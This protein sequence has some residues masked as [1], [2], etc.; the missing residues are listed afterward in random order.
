M[1]YTNEDVSEGTYDA[2]PMPVEKGRIR[3]FYQEYMTNGGTPEHS[4]FTIRCKDGTMKNV[5]A[6]FATIQYG[7]KPAIL[8]L[9][10]DGLNPREAK[11]DFDALDAPQT[12]AE[13]KVARVLTALLKELVREE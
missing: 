8:A 11:T 10:R 9:V 12:N 6:S 13:R 1:G 3:R 4:K 2:H 5:R 7:G